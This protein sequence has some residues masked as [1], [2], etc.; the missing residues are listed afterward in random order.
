[1]GILN[2]V[3]EI[4]RASTQSANRGDRAGETS[5]GAYWCDDCAERIRDVDATGETPPNCPDCGEEMRFERS[6]AATGCAC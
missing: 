1:M 2:A 3:G 5:T 6:A 4:L